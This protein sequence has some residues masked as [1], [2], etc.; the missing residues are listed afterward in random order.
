MASDDKVLASNGRSSRF[1]WARSVKGPTVRGLA[2]VGG[3]MALALAA[4]DD[5]PE[6]YL[7]KAQ[8]APPALV[9]PSL[10]DVRSLREAL[11]RC[12]RAMEA[13]ADQIA[14]VAAQADAPATPEVIVRA[15]DA[16]AASAK[17]IGGLPIWGRLK[18]PCLRA[19]Y[20][21][22]ATATGTLRVLAAKE[23]A[24]GVEALRNQI[25]DQVAA[26]RACASEISNA[27]R[28]AAA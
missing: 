23:R 6:D 20:A 14:G 21:R 12:E 13:G 17:A 3:A 28:E 9:A 16:C 15:R 5:R 22:E 11:R 27:E 8:A 24:L 19:A 4:C 7:P 10:A 1:S 2:F 25:A 26:S 18:D